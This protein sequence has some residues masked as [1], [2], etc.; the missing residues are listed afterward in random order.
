MG[1]HRAAENRH[2]VGASTRSVCCGSRAA[3]AKTGERREFRRASENYLAAGGP[4][5]SREGRVTYIDGRGGGGFAD[6]V[7]KYSGSLDC[8]NCR[9]RGGNAYTLGAGG[10][11][12]QAYET[13]AHRMPAPLLFIHPGWIAR[14]L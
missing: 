4:S 11:P 8:P 5:R 1:N 7:Y 14:G 13:A 9:S 12:H 6:C 2:L 10:K 3:V